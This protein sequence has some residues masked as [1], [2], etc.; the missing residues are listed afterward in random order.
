MEGAIIFILLPFTFVVFVGPFIAGNYISAYYQKW[1]LIGV[2]VAISPCIWATWI[3][4]VPFALKTQKDFVGLVAL[5]FYLFLICLPPFFAN[6]IGLNRYSIPVFPVFGM[7]CVLYQYSAFFVSASYHKYA[8]DAL[9][10][11][12]IVLR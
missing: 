2:M 8:L 1:R 6:R 11:G 10:Y 12:R 4:I 5:G 7:L 9:G 3:G